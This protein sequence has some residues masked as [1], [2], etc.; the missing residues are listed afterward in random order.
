MS[1]S[2]PPPGFPPPYSSP[3]TGTPL[4]AAPLGASA[5]QTLP[6]KGKN[7]AAPTRKVVGLSRG[8]AFLFA[9]LALGAVAYL[10]QADSAPGLY[11]ARSSQSLAEMT[12]FS[13]SMLRISPVSPDLLERDAISAETEEGVR[14]AVAGLYGQ[15]TRFPLSEGQQLR[16]DL[17]TGAT[18]EL[19]PLGA[20]ERLVS[21][22]ASIA[23]AVAG[24][25]RPGDRVDVV[26]VDPREG[27][28][29][30]LARDVEVVAVR[31]SA[32]QLAGLSSEQTGPEGREL[33]PEDLQPA[34]PIPG[35][36]TLRVDAA[37]ASQVA[38]ASSEGELH[39]LYRN[40]SAV[41]VPSPAVSLLELICRSTPI[42]IRPVACLE[43]P[44]EESLPFDELFPTSG[45]DADV[46]PDAEGADNAPN[47]G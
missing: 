4:G 17:F 15:V 14:E 18:R 5:P 45:E 34:Q 29:G 2:T 40:S 47:E 19:A 35:M 12:E 23:N 36:Y 3:S 43:L 33:S 20:G 42:E 31:L 21:V 16:A 27:V 22:P 32:D 13:E 41:D 26:V 1:S 9:L 11:V 37:L 39:L 10:T 24:T 7:P 44:I 38:V 46:L 6:S 8:L 25:L 28:A 30:V